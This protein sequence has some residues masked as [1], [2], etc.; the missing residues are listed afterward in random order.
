MCPEIERGP[1]SHRKDMAVWSFLF[2]CIGIRFSHIEICFPHFRLFQ[3]CLQEMRALNPRANRK[4]DVLIIGGGVVGAAVARELSRYELDILLVEKEADLSFGTSKANSGIV[5]SGI[6]DKPGSLKSKLCIEGSKLFSTLAEELDILY[7]GCGTLIAAKSEE[8]L[9]HLDELYENAKAVG[10]SGVSRLSREEVL[11]LEPNLSKDIAGGIRTEGGGVVLPFDLVFALAENAAANGASISVGTEVTS[12][13]EEDG[14]YTIETN[15]GQI[16]S[17]Y[18]VNAAGLFS[19]NIARMIGDDSFSIT[20]VKGEEYLLDRRL[21]GLVNRT[22]FPVPTKESKGILV[23]PTAEGNIM[24]G[25]TSDT[26]ESRHDKSTS[27]HGWERIYGETVKILPSLSPSDLI[28]SFSGLRAR[29]NTG[30]FIIEPSPASPRFINAAGI[31]S[32]GLTAAPAIA[33]YIRQLLEEAG[34]R[35]VPKKAFNPERRVVRIRELSVEKRAAI[36][37]RDPAYANIICR[38]ELVSEGEIRDA[39]RRGATTLDG[40]KLRTRSGMGRCQGGFCT[41]RIIEIMRRELGLEPEEITKIGPGSPLL[42]GYL[43]PDTGTGLVASPGISPFDSVKAEPCSSPFNKN[44][45]A[46]CR[47]SFAGGKCGTGGK[48]Q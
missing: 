12:I 43:R 22:I 30:D 2:A 36:M 11:D 38:C 8:E 3:F 37:E 14:L 40:I 44:E 48:I 45:A 10:L 9:P 24:I 35:L 5:H 26:V 31:D 15:R 41:P 39:I 32:P 19:D 46:L 33:G 18:I 42:A 27:R 47:S 4:V 29:G 20:P 16:R 34:L 28:A 17:R 23:I 13:K 7:K 6:H 1:N 21:Q 25:P